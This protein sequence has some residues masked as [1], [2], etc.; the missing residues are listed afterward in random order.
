M[1]LRLVLAQGYW[2]ESHLAAPSEDALRREVELI[3]ELGFN[4]A[5]IH[6]KVADPRFLYWADRL[7]LMIWG[8]TAAAYEFSPRAG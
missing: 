6:Q 4:A 7:G 2:P 3:K 5:R 1:F 8:E